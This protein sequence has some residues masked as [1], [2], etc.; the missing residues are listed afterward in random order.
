MSLLSGLSKVFEE[1]VINEIVNDLE[2]CGSMVSNFQY[3]FRSSL[4]TGDV[5][6]V[7]SDKITRAFNRFGAT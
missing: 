1:L 2:N 5:L 6:T 7:V 4:S 3:G